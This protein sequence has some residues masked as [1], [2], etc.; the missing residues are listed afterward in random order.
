MKK[1]GLLFLAIAG[2]LA[3]AVNPYAARVNFTPEL[4]VSEEYTDNLFLDY[5]DDAKV[6]DFI[7][8]AGLSLTLEVLG[9]TDGLEVNYTPSYS[10]F[11]DNDDLDYWRHSARL[12]YLARFQAQHPPAADQYLSG[13]R[14]SPGS[15]R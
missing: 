14:R 13:N 11:A 15:F 4:F 3:T 12:R 2:V 7:T 10:T 9:Q 8:T 5:D 6:D 1:T